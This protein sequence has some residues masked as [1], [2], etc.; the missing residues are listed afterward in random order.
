MD[1]PSPTTEQA[2]R[3]SFDHPDQGTRYESVEE[4]AEELSKYTIRSIILLRNQKED[5]RKENLCYQ[6]KS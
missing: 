3:D 5:L 2:I 6:S 1:K 4:L